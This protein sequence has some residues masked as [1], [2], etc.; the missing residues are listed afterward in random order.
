[1]GVLKNGD[2]KNMQKIKKIFAEINFWKK[3]KK[4]LWIIYNFHKMEIEDKYEVAN[5]LLGL[6][7]VT[8]LSN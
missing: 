3:I 8:Y 6:K 1:M 5:G 7:S 4:I 2:T